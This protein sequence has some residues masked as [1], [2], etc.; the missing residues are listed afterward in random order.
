[1]IQFK[2]FGDGTDQSLENNSMRFALLVRID[3]DV[4]IP[5]LVLTP[6][7]DPASVLTDDPAED[8]LMGS[9]SL[10]TCWHYSAESA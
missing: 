3:G 6:L 7:V 1:M 10:P 8:A 2:T 5:S 4:A 9:D